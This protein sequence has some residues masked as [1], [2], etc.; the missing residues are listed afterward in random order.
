MHNKIF[1]RNSECISS[2]IFLYL[3]VSRVHRS[4]RSNV[5]VCIQGDLKKGF[6]VFVF[7]LCFFPSISQVIPSA[8][9]CYHLRSC[10]RLLLGK[11]LPFGAEPLYVASGKHVFD[12]EI[13]QTATIL[14]SWT[15]PFQ[16]ARE[17]SGLSLQPLG[18]GCL[19]GSV[20]LSFSVHRALESTDTTLH[21]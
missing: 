2:V 4:N 16:L 13:Q 21:E 7:S 5:C 3:V 15:P 6:F 14:R 11:K 1:K 18:Q 12:T 20:S 19:D 9:I 8:T 17:P 10:L